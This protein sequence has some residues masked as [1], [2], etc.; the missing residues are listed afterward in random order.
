MTSSLSRQNYITKDLANY[1]TKMDETPKFLSLI[2]YLNLM[3]LSKINCRI[4]KRKKNCFCLLRRLTGAMKS[5][6]NS[7]CYHKPIKLVSH[8]LVLKKFIIRCLTLVNV[9]STTCEVCHNA[10]ILV[11]ISSKHKKLRG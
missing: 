4:V 1:I 9:L 10:K 2:S 7:I 6:R 3:W 11:Q 8:T 5:K